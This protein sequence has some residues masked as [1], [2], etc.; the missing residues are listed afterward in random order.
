VLRV[1]LTAVGGRGEESASRPRRSLVSHRLPSGT[2]CQGTG[3]RR[4]S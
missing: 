2:V 3:R 1:C 4:P